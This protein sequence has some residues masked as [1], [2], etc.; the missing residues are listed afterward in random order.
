LTWHLHPPGLTS[1]NR[2]ASPPPWV[3]YWSN[4]ALFVELPHGLVLRI[5]T[6]RHLDI[7]THAH[8]HTLR[9]VRHNA[10]PTV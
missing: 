6:G 4:H 2:H 9:T 8:T 10:W 3:I 7:H 5:R 1:A